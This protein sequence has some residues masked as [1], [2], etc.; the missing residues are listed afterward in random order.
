MNYYTKMILY[1]FV[2]KNINAIKFIKI[3]D[4]KNKFAV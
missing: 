2:T 4:K 3:I 1:I